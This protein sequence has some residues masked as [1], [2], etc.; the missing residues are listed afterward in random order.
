MKNLNLKGLGSIHYT[1]RPVLPRVGVGVP[2]IIQSATKHLETQRSYVYNV[3]LSFCVGARPRSR[4]QPSVE[5]GRYKKNQF[6]WVASIITRD[7]P[8]W[9]MS[10]GLVHHRDLKFEAHQFKREAKQQATS[11]PYLSLVSILFLR[12][13]C[14]LFRPLYKI[15]M[16]EGLT[17]LDTKTGKD[18]LAS[19]CPKGM[20]VRIDPP[21]SMFSSTTLGSSQESA[22]TAS[23]PTNLLIIA[24]MAQAHES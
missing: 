17:T 13:S 16:A 10:K 22:V 7:Q 2:C 4:H 15:V 19:K 12:A 14:P 21:P 6:Q 11:L 9:A 1:Y 8:Q 20:G 5:G 18:A 24:Q 3:V 23:P